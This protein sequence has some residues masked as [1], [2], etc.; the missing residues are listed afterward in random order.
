[1]K[2]LIMRDLLLITLS[3]VFHRSLLEG[4]QQKGEVRKRKKKEREWGG[5]G[6]F[7]CSG[8]EL[9]SVVR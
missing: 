5:Y 2:T 1:M 4:E 9:R 7:G 6:A 3:R 8:V